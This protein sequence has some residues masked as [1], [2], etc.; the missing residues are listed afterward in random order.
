MYNSVRATRRT[1]IEALAN[2]LY[3]R[4]L[5]SLPIETICRAKLIMNVTKKMMIRMSTAI[6]K[7][8]VNR[9]N[10]CSPEKSA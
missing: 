3:V 4:K 10:S 9:S 1:Y 5:T 6:V 8:M 2:F 7:M